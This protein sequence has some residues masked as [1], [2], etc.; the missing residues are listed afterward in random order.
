MVPAP[1]T[2]RNP[3]DFRIYDLFPPLSSLK[4]LFVSP[5]LDI[6]RFLSNQVKYD[7]SFIGEVG[8]LVSPMSSHGTSKKFVTKLNQRT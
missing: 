8:R 5:S 2:A 7:R 1:S 6:R 4:F 3:P